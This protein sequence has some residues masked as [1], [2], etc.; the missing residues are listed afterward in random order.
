MTQKYQIRL[1]LREDLDRIMEIYDIARQFMR[2][3]GN[4]TQWSGGY[5]QRELLEADIV[6]RKLFVVTSGERIR[7]VFYFSMGPDPTYGRIED[8]DWHCDAPY[9]VIH[10]IASDGSGGIFPAA[11]EF[12]LTQCSY[13]RIDTHHDNL[14]MQHVVQKHGFRRCGIIFLPDGS[15]RIAY[16]RI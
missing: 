15:P 2:R 9:G 5:P 7:G 12:C 11:M 10:R 8:G 16:D 6:R 4:A 3:E 14:P 13:L 1:A